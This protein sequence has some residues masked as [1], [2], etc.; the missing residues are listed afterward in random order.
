MKLHRIAQ[1]LLAAL[2]LAALPHGSA[3]AGVQ[4]FTIPVFEADYYLSR[5]AQHISQ[6]RVNERI[7]AEFPNSDQNHGL[8]RAIPETYDNHGVSLLVNKVTGAQDAALNYSISSD[9]NN[10]VLKIGDADRYVHGRQTYNISYTMAN[11]TTKPEAGYDA[12]F[13]DVNGDQWQQVFGAVTARVHLT[14]ELAAALTADRTRCFTG[15]RGSTTS[16]CTVTKPTASNGHAITFTTTRPLH[17]G[18]TLTYELGFAPGTF[19]AYTVPRAELIS[20]I[21][22]IV[23]LGI[24]PP[25]LALGFV[26]HRWRRTGRDPAGR[27]TIIAEYTPPKDVSVIASSVILR[28]SF[29][30]KAISAQIIDLAVRRY[31]KIYETKIK[32]FLHDQT[33]YEVEL[34]RAPDGLRTEETAVLNLLF[35]GGLTVGKRVSLES[36]KNKLHEGAAT[37]GDDVSTRLTSTGYFLFKPSKA[38][39]PFYLAG[40]GLGIL[41]FFML[42]YSVGV[43]AAGAI[44][45]IAAQV[46]P[47][48]TA[49]GVL[50][51]E[52]LLGLK[53]YMQLAEADRIKVLQ[54]PHGKLTEKIDTTDNTALVKLYEKLLPFAMLFGIE[55]DWAKEFAALYQHDPGWYSGTSSFNA[56]YFAGSIAGFSTASAAS[57]TAP[58]SS[59]SGGSA[60]GG[61]GGG[62]GGGW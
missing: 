60:G 51:R 39:F 8:L 61:G 6:L 42:P 49:K 43:I 31:L 4:D 55:K 15:A 32:K 44:L 35:E 10:L 36:L 7:V 16:D 1:F 11:V 33:T 52:Y 50:L 34:V 37:I 19:A 40:S 9:N 17:P 30:P 47:A 41:G 21:A 53:L 58:S 14:L 3:Q 18:E 26:T 22:R 29:E 62:G 56:G 24:L 23:F 45:L 38:K 20:H 12:H 25:L 48:R 46:M 13:W 59:G 5:D 54:S 27:G 2:M 28:E 57:F